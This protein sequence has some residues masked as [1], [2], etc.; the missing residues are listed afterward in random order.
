LAAD[1][2]L[3]VE[4]FAALK[5][6]GRRITLLCDLIDARRYVARAKRGRVGKVLEALEPELRE[7]SKAL[8]QGPT[9]A[10]AVSRGTLEVLRAEATTVAPRILAQIV[11]LMITSGDA[12]AEAV[13]RW[14]NETGDKE[15]AVA[16]AAA[17]VEVADETAIVLALHHPRANARE[18]V[19]E[20]RGLRYRACE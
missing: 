3:L 20:Y 16:A 8:V 14:L 1:D 9:R 11:P 18:L 6:H 19:L 12:P 7:I 10:P 17:A 15:L 2:D 4:S 5:S 13:R